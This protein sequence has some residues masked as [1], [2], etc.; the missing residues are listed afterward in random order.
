VTATVIEVPGGNHN[1]SSRPS[2]PDPPA[3]LTNCATLSSVICEPTVV[4]ASSHIVPGSPH[5]NTS[6]VPVGTSL[7]FTI[8]SVCG[9]SVWSA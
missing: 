3:T 6:L 4:N 5:P 1:V 7:A 9:S 8:V 2:R